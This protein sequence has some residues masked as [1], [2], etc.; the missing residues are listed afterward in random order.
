MTG[1]YQEANPQSVRN[2]IQR[3]HPDEG[4]D[5]PLCDHHLEHAA[6]L[7]TEGHAQPH[8]PGSLAHGIAQRRRCHPLGLSGICADALHQVGPNDGQV[9]I[10]VSHLLPQHRQEQPGI[11]RGL[12]M[13]DHFRAVVLLQG[14]ARCESDTLHSNR[15]DPGH[16]LSKELSALRTPTRRGCEG[17]S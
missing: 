17:P 11:P 6:G 5:N 9:R 2:R 3:V 15:R 14:D 4:E 13:E 8:L 10:Q 7:G 16:Q 12:G 1:E